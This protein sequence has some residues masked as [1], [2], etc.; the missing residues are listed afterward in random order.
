LNTTNDEDIVNQTHQV[1]FEDTT[2][3]IEIDNRLPFQKLYSSVNPYP[4]ETPRQ[5]L[6]RIVRLTN[7]PWGPS[8]IGG[9]AFMTFDPLRTLVQNSPTHAMILGNIINGGTFGGMYRYLRCSMEVTFKLNTT[10]YHQ[11]VVCVGWTP[12]LVP[13]A[14]YT[15]YYAPQMDGTLLSASVQDQ[16]I[17]T[18]PFCSSR[19]HYD[20][21]GSGSYLQ[22]H[23]STVW[24]VVINTL[25]ATQPSITDTIDISCWIQLKDIDIYGI[26]PQ[27]TPSDMKIKA[28]KLPEKKTTSSDDMYEEQADFN[29]G[30]TNKESQTKQ[31]AGLSAKGVAD[32]VAPI[33][34]TVPVVGDIVR[35]GSMIMNMSK[36][37]SDQAVTYTMDRQN[38]GHS[39]QTGEDFSEP[40]SPFPSFNV[41]KDLGMESSEMHAVDFAKKPCMLYQ[42]TAT[43]KGI[44]DQLIIHPMNYFVSTQRTEPD[45]LAFTTS[46]FNYWRG[47]IKFL[48]QFVGSPFYSCRFRISVSH[49]NAPPATIGDGTGHFSRVIDVKGD[50]WSSITIPYLNKRVWSYTLATFEPTY[51]D[52][53]YLTIEALTD[54]MGS[55]LPATAKIYINIYRG[56]GNDFQL[57]GPRDASGIDPPSTVGRANKNS[58]LASDLFL[59]Q[60]SLKSKFS[61]TFEGITDQQTGMTEVGLLMSSTSSTLS[62]LCKS[63]QDYQYPPAFENFSYPN[64]VSS[65]TLQK[66]PLFFLA[67]AFLYWRGSRRIKVT[68]S[69]TTKSF[70]LCNFNQSINRSGPQSLFDE[71]L[72]SAVVPWFSVEA[73]YPTDGRDL[74]SAF[75]YAK[76]AICYPSTAINDVGYYWLAAGDDFAYYFPVQPFV[77]VL[78][79]PPVNKEKVK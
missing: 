69:E 5:L 66:Q 60:C 3:T 33:L 50:T 77:S 31:H 57:A 32:L 65:P 21:Y 51:H 79:T 19:P 76:P 18:I 2:E 26:V 56:A 34:S 25:V 36:P 75:T 37:T 45:Y 12:Q 24:M 74:I 16:A 29:R 67:T 20:L 14:C 23:P 15:K 7:I 11:G 59:E 43:T 39:M 41:T 17:V 22:S 55:S 9:A 27:T 46:M 78:F 38:R 44:L 52:Y 61:E 42:L 8:G 68:N 28:K 35:L 72:A 48:F 30:K 13:N 10:P 40:L 49:T 54:V 70:S 73:Y 63:F 58:L 53:A 47:S 64:V 62:D 4:D 71:Q 6:S 1:R